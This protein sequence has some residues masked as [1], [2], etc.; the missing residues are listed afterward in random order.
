MK[1]F[2]SLNTLTIS[3]LS[4]SFLISLSISYLFYIKH[5]EKKNI[6][7][8]NFLVKKISSIAYEYLNKGQEEEDLI[9]IDET[10]IQ[11]FKKKKKRKEKD[12]FTEINESLLISALNIC[13]ERI[14]LPLELKNIEFYTKKKPK[15]LRKFILQMKSKNKI[16]R[17]NASFSLRFYG[18]EGVQILSGFLGIE[19]SSSIRFKICESLLFTQSYDLI[20]LILDSAVKEYENGNMMRFSQYIAILQ[21]HSEITANIISSRY[22]YNKA[23]TIIG[24]RI[25]RFFPSSSLEKLLIESLMSDDN[26]LSSEAAS[27][28]YHIVPTMLDSQFFLRHKN[29]EIRKYAIKALG[30]VQNIDNFDRLLQFLLEEENEQY[31]ISA[32]EDAIKNKDEFKDKLLDIFFKIDDISIKI[33]LAPILESFLYYFL[34]EK[35]WFLNEKIIDLIEYCIKNGLIYNIVSYLNN[36][37]DKKTEEILILKIVQVLD[38][39]NFK[40]PE[41]EKRIKIFE[42][43]TSSLNDDICQTH[44]FPPKKKIETQ[45]APT[46]SKK[47]K[48][49][50]VTLSI[51]LFLAPFILFYLLKKE[52]FFS[53]FTWLKSFIIFYIKFFGYYAL[54]INLISFIFLLFANLEIIKQN[55]QKN[56]I[57]YLNYF[58]K[59]VLPSISVIVPAFREEATIV[60]NVRSLLALK[61]PSFEVIVV[62]DGSPDN[63]MKVLKENFELER[64]PFIHSTEHID[65][66]PIIGVYKSKLHS[67]LFVIDK[68]NGGKADSLNAGINL[69]NCQ[70]VCGIDADSLLEQ[71]ALLHAISPIIESDEKIIA[72]G[73]K[74]MPVNGCIVENGSLIK[75]ALGKNLF[76]RFQT[77]EYLRAYFTGRLGWSYIKSLLIISGAF[78]V[79]ERKAVLEI[80]GYMTFRTKARQNT[81][82]EDMELIVRLRR[83]SIEK[84]EKAMINYSINATCW[85]EVPESFKILRK[86]R[87]RWQRGLI[88]ILLFHRK[89]IFNKNYGR[90][91]TIALPYYLIFETLGPFYEVMGLFF[92]ILAIFLKIFTLPLFLFLFLTSIL[93]G[94]FISIFSLAIS[95][96]NVIYF[97]WYEDM[98]L[99]LIGFLENLGFRQLMNLLRLFAYFNYIIGKSSWGMMK[100]KGFKTR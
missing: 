99:I 47:D 27:V 100:R 1:I 22:P 17:A 12:I 20:P 61:Y 3:I 30:R 38:I 8:I 9:V 14:I 50:L 65:T 71:D 7:I 78:G 6:K 58:Q 48:P 60:Q 43:F 76:A 36:N 90:V 86:Q 81:V 72:T 39:V 91:G 41:Y 97:N 63:T 75:I 44:N 46:A 19:K 73:G 42:E 89:M 64:I 57:S 15:L 24:I 33:K 37:E 45:K 74:I 16:K 69:A 82:G 95:E 29:N 51:I 21:D 83:Y 52:N 11:S 77:M 2:N 55:R 34:E 49:L 94:I 92:T 96:K 23:E 35:D 53:F 4:L 13:C 59:G 10:N 68:L 66:A 98:I 5:K 32:L 67:N 26:D 28:I 31:A 62:N 84:K 87:D 79:F 93:L 85:T 54:T 56:S 70:Y 80:G 40:K 88:E 25:C 18:F